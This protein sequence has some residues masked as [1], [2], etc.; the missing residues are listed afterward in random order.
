MQEIGQIEPPQDLSHENGFTAWMNLAPRNYFLYLFN[1][2]KK[3][4][5][6][7]LQ[8]DNSGEA[9][10]QKY[11]FQTY[12]SRS[13]DPDL[14]P[15]MFS[16]TDAE[17][18]FG[19]PRIDYWHPQILIY[20][21][22]G[23]SKSEPNIFHLDLMF[24][25]SKLLTAYRVRGPGISKLEF[26]PLKKDSL[27][28][29]TYDRQKCPDF[30]KRSQITFDEIADFTKDSSCTELWK[31]YISINKNAQQALK[32]LKIGLRLPA[33]KQISA[34]FAFKPI[35]SKSQDGTLTPAE[36]AVIGHQ[37]AL[38]N[39]ADDLK[40]KILE[41]RNL[42]FQYSLATKVKNF[43]QNERELLELKTKLVKEC[44]DNKVNYAE[45]ILAKQN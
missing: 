23:L 32:N 42:W 14:K 44:G 34:I 3:E 20:D 6:A 10:V 27:L 40:R 1:D 26:L 17:K 12:E 24:D 29:E 22:I 21:F 8:I 15:I 35:F 19:A 13:A 5:K 38:Q 37:K 9:K 36:A 31:G 43:A 30:H 4:N 39:Q 11:L 28:G 7:Y 18:N 25:R 33:N 41:I 16:V 2:P 45:S